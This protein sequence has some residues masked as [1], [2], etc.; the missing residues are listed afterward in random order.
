MASPS[1]NA[2]NGDD[3]ASPNGDSPIHGNPSHDGAS[4][5]ASRDDP[6]RRAS[7]LQ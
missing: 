6:I 7:E 1:H 3:G 2:T 4:R 5:D